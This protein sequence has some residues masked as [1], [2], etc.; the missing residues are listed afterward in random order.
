MTGATA[1]GTAPVAELT[2]PVAV[3]ATDP[4][5]PVTVPTAPVAVLVAVPTGSRTT[6]RAL[7]SVTDGTVAEGT[8]TG[9]SLMLGVE[10]DGVVA[11]GRG[12]R[13]PR[14]W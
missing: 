6:C 3:P 2:V 11:A 12:P 1:L 4:P 10:T 7:G 13:P 8:V 14:R 5:A 9:P